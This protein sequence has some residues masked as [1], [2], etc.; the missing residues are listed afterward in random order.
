MYCSPN[1]SASIAFRRRRRLGMIVTGILALVGVVC[2]FEC[3]E[4]ANTLLKE[5]LQGLR[6]TGPLSFF[7]AMAI[8]PAAGFPLA[9]FVLAAGPVFGPTIGVGHTIAFAVLALA[10]NV[11][12]CYGLAA[13]I[14]RNHVL[15]LLKWMGLKQ[16]TFDNVTA[17]QMVAIVR[18]VPGL[19]FWTQS[20][21]LGM[22]R[23]DFGPYVVLSTLVPATY[24][25]CVVLGGNALM[26]GHN[27]ALLTSLALLGGAAIFVQIWRRRVEKKGRAGPSQ[28]DTRG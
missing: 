21:F 12:L 10:A 6:A 8:L 25:V 3:R 27:Q 18:L 2:F 28:L 20:Y 13:Y 15:D 1:P 11:T 26:Q 24:V 7:A 16:P 19:P 23:V 14:L 5:V 9:P 22:M 4:S 17:W